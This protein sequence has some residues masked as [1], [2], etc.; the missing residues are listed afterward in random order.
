MMP[1]P[2]FST[3]PQIPNI[4]ISKRPPVT[5]IVF[6]ATTLENTP[7]AYH[8][9]TF[10]NPNPTIMRTTM[11]REI[12]PEPEPCREATLTLWLR[13]LRVHK[14][15]ERV[16]GLKDAPNRE[17]NMRG[18]NVEG[19]RP[20]EIEARKGS[21]THF[22]CWIEDYP[23]PDGLK[24]SSHVGSYYGKRDPDNFLHLFKGAICMQKWLMPIACHKF[25]Y[26]LKDSA[27]IGWNIQKVGSILNYE[28]LKA[29]FR[30][31]FNQ[32]K[33]FTKTHLGVHNNKQR[34]GKS[35]RA[36]ITRYIDDT[37]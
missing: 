22:V 25:T 27:R 37:L 4:S 28:D 21:V 13:S 11:K 35:T 8:A 23:L 24:M 6:A 10:T 31:H 2:G 12:E 15:R 33:I 34:E 1:P 36:F 20:L 26:T 14:Q 5:T 18:R 30:L 16:V 32:Q 29:K 9:S 3:P 19:I 7:F 17:G